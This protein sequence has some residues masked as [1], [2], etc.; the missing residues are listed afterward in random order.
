LAELSSLVER[1]ANVMEA[2]YI[3]VWLRK[4]NPSLDDDK[5]LDVIAHGE[6]REISR[7]IAALEGSPTT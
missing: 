3:P 7:L 1:L 4:P 2:T 5:P 6:Y